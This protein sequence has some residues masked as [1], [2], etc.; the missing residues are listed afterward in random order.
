MTEV[1]QVMKVMVKVNEELLLT[2]SCNARKWAP[3]KC[4]KRSVEH[5]KS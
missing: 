5:K 1:C 2:Q 3:D 4:G